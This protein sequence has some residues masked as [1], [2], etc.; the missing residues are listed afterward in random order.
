MRELSNS[1]FQ[2]CSEAM[3]LYEPLCANKDCPC[4]SDCSACMI[5]QTTLQSVF[6]FTSFRSGQLDA[7]VP[8][9]H[10]RQGRIQDLRKGG[11]Y[12]QLL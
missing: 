12:A 4:Y 8:A 5:L 10:G 11:G 2:N 1:S 7:I 6:G 3:S 9:L